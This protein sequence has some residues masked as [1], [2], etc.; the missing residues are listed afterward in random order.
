MV[1]SV[2]ALDRPE[3]SLSFSVVTKMPFT[4]KRKKRPDISAPMNFEHRIHAG[5]D[6]NTNQFTGLP[7]VRKYD[8]LLVNVVIL[9]ITSLNL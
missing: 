6:P 7:K 8:L 1:L 5:F 3:V 9:F 4:S 2:S